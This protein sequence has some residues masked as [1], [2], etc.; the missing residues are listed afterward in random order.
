M[1]SGTR[2]NLTQLASL[3]EFGRRGTLGAAADALGY[4]PGAVSQHLA[5]LER[6]VGAPLI[7]KTG[8]TRGL[9]DA[10]RVLLEHADVVLRAERAA[11]RAVTAAQHDVA[12]PVALGTWG[13]TAATLLAPIVR[14][15]ATEFPRV[16]LRSQEVDLD[17]TAAAVLHGRLDVAFG[18]DYADEPLPRHPEIAIIELQREAFSIATCRGPEAVSDPFEAAELNEL[19]WILPPATSQYGRAV[20]VG[21]R[22]RGVEPRVVHEVTDTAASLHLAAAGLGATVITP[23]MRRLSPSLELGVRPMAEPMTRQ[24]VLL[25]PSADR[26]RPVSAFVDV[27]RRVNQIRDET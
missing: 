27:A 14:R 7:R 18:L 10:G 22:R 20:L 2:L 26:P 19:S 5:A 17:D 9:T 25:V 23:L 6:A 11:M 1:E 8:R 16:D 4:T 3:L 15:L 21:L 24:V 12:G 13:S